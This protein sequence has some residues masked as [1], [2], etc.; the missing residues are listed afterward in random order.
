MLKR[1]LVFALFMTASLQA[2]Q[3]KPISV[4]FSPKGKYA[5]RSF[6]VN[7]DAEHSIA[8]QVSMTTRD[9]DIEGKESR[10]VVEDDFIIYPSQMILLPGEIQT[11]RVS[12]A[13][14]PDIEQEKAY[15]IISEQLPIN[16]QD[17]PEAEQ[18]QGQFNIS[19]RYVGAVYVVPDEARA[20]IVIESF[21]S[22]GNKVIAVLHN[23][24]KAHLMLKD[25]SL[26]F[27]AGGKE[28]ILEVK[29][30]QALAQTNMLAGMRRRFVF[31]RPSDL[32]KGELS[33]ALKA[34]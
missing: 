25:E 34:K 7:N 5:T 20:E 29:N 4:E 23:K 15:R 11:V 33:L 27:S 22:E 24:G 10:Q 30:H 1:A 12:W 32:P 18:A 26:V 13:G 28:S 14:S 17:Q 3:F 9:V 2:F 31:D 19:M 16:M 6:L 21:K 8:I